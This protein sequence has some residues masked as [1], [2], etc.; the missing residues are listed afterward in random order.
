MNGLFGEDVEENKIIEH[1]IKQLLLFLND[2]LG[3]YNSKFV[4]RNIKRKRKIDFYDLFFYMLYY[5]SSI[6]ETHGS[7]NTN[8]FIENNIDVSENAFINKLIKL[9]C[10]CIKK[11]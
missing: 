3:E 6:N 2:T 11:Y 1:N 9:D 4:K 7:I 5:N 8:F 10:Y